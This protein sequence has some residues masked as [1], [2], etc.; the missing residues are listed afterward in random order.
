MVKTKLTK[1]YLE[2]SISLFLRKHN[3]SML[4]YKSKLSSFFEM[5]M[6]NDIV[7]AYEHLGYSVKPENIFGK[8]FKY[9]N[10]TSGYIDRFSYFSI[11][12]ED[13]KYWVLH[14]VKIESR[15]Y[16]K[17][18]LTADISIVLPNASQRTVIDKRSLD[19]IPNN[20]LLTFFECKLMP[21]FPELLASFVGL[22]F[23][24]KPECMICNASKKQHIAPSLLCSG[25]GSYNTKVFKNVIIGR[26]DINVCENLSY[27]TLKAMQ[28]QNEL[29]TL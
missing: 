13:M 22:V 20:S 23:V 9:K 17:C 1:S 27:R 19:Y 16:S 6:Y 10:T 28:R 12:K 2:K 15:V 3:T 7:R 11:E 8:T 4:T 14:N 5:K 25:N 24:L 21:P 29:K 26:H 18:Y